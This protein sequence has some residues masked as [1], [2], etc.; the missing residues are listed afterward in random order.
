MFKNKR[1][2]IEVPRLISLTQYF[3]VDQV[4]RSI[5]STEKPPH[6]QSAL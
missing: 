3:P 1:E 6:H 2:L 5:E 4:Y